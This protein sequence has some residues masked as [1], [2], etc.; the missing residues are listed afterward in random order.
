ME[1]VPEE[2]GHIVKVMTD[3]GIIILRCTLGKGHEEKHYD[4]AFNWE[5]NQA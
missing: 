3:G 2:C 4:A 5:W 1:G